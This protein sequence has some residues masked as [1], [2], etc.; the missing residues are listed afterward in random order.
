MRIN[1]IG[2]EVGQKICTVNVWIYLNSFVFCLQSK[3]T[4][5]SKWMDKYTKLKRVN[6]ETFW[7]MKI[8][9]RWKGIHIM[10]SAESL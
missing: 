7:E 8:K 9:F 5:Q 4:I 6:M 3:D 10:F 1:S 2:N